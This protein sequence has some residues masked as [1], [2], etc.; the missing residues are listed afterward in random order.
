MWGWVVTRNQK[1][2]LRLDDL[3]AEFADQLVEA[4][5]AVNSA[6]RLFLTPEAARHCGIHESNTITNQQFAVMAEDIAALRR[7]LEWED[8]DCLAVRFL[9]ACS[10]AHDLS[11]AHRGSAETIA[12]RLLGEALMAMSE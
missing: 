2:F 12:Q 4:L 3:E 10:E 5:Q 11:D 9:A 8:A 1:L 7:K 6:W